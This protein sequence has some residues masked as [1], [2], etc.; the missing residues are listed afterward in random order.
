VWAHASAVD[1]ARRR[2]TMKKVT[3]LSM[4]LWLSG[5]PGTLKVL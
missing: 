4:A 3:S 2:R 1:P 5:R